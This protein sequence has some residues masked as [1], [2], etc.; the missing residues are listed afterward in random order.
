M[1]KMPICDH[2]MLH[3]IL[4]RYQLHYTYTF[5]YYFSRDECKVRVISNAE[6]VA[7]LQFSLCKPCRLNMD[8][9]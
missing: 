5:V 1:I 4:V 8:R 3:G 9:A 6:L 2:G 7:A